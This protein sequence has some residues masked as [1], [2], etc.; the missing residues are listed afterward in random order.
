ML[1]QNQRDSSGFISSPLENLHLTICASDLKKLVAVSKVIMGNM[2]VSTLLVI[3]AT[4]VVASSYSRPLLGTGSHKVDV[5]VG[6]DLCLLQG[7]QL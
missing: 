1:V 3:I 7:A 2:D 4:V 6:V 5:R